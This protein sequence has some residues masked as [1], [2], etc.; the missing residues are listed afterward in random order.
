M[1]YDIFKAE[2]GFYFGSIK[3]DKS[4]KMLRKVTDNEV[5]QMFTD[6]LRRFCASQKKNACIVS[7]SEGK[8]VFT[9]MLNVEQK[10][11]QADGKE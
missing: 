6:Y 4:A 2:D 5:I 10:E 3:K 7:D 8:I 9:A 1:I 11:E